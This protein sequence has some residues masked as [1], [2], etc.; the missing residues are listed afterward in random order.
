MLDELLQLGAVE[1]VE[2]QCVRVKSRIPISV[3]RTPGAIIAL[4][5][6]CSDLLRTLGKNMQRPIPPMFEA[7]S[8]VGDADPDLIPVVRRAIEKQGASFINSANSIL[9]RSRST[10]SAGQPKSA[11][12]RRLGVTVYYF[13]GESDTDSVTGAKPRRRTNLRR[14]RTKT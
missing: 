14:R 10:S 4:G 1:Q 13:E 7:T 3:G 2:K 12:K 5:D 6:R 8:L 9:A 11:V